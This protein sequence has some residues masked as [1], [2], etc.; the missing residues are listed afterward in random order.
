MANSNDNKQE[1]EASSVFDEF[2]AFTKNI[3][4]LLSWFATLAVV[5][6]VDIVL[7]FGPPWPAGNFVLFLIAVVQFAILM[8]GFEYWRKSSSIKRVRRYMLI[9]L[10]IGLTILFTYVFL[11]AS[12]VGQ[13]EIVDADQDGGT[14]RNIVQY[15]RGTEYKE[16]IREVYF[17]EAGGATTDELLMKDF[18]YDVEQIWERSGIVRN[19]LLLFIPWLLFWGFLTAGVAA[20]TSIQMKRADRKK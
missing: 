12:F 5:P 13:I 18:D 14:T 19:R 16:I 11:F 8:I 7:Q 2:F 6:F 17:S 9:S 1:T 3:K 15:V 20:F 10:G 4:T